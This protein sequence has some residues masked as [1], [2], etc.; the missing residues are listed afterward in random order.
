VA[1]LL[2]RGGASAR[3]IA[4]QLGHSRVSMTQD[5]DLGRKSVAGEVAQV[6]NLYDPDQGREGRGKSA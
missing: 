5:Y 2:D 4:D 1:T 3:L 6:L